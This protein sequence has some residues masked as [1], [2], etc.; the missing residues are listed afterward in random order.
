MPDVPKVSRAMLDAA[1]P[2]RPAQDAAPAAQAPPRAPIPPARESRGPDSPPVTR[3]QVRSRRALDGLTLKQR[4]FVAYFLGAAQGNATQAASLAG[5]ANGNRVLCAE[6]A[7]ALLR[8]PKVVAYIDRKTK[9]S[10]HMSRDETLAEVAKVARADVPISE[11]GK[12]AALTLAA[13]VHRLVGEESSGA[14]A[15]VNVGVAVSLNVAQEMQGRINSYAA[16]LRRLTAGALP[17]SPHDGET[18]RPSSST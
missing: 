4:S 10:R 6:I 12:L 14:P 1:T 15:P 7:S 9:L 5:Y 18:S 13:R 8:Q 17:A 16:V 3:A 2:Q 11:R